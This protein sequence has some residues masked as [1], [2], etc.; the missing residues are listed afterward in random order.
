MQCAPGTQI[1]SNK[2][3]TEM[4]MNGHDRADCLVKGLYTQ[5]AHGDSL[6]EID[7]PVWV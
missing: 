2:V 4:L 7:K 6:P 1:V 3:C 5:A